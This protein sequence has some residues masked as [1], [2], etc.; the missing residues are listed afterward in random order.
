MADGKVVV[1]RDGKILDGHY[2]EVVEGENLTPPDLGR[3]L[4]DS[5]RKEGVPTKKGLKVMVRTIEA[6]G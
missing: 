2:V 3:D 6:R 4:V 5:V 1:L